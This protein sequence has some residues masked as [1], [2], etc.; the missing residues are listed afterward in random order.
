MRGIVKVVVF[1]F[2]LVTC[3]GA[4]ALAAQGG[5]FGRFFKK[6]AAEPR[7]EKPVSPVPQRTVSR[8]KVPPKTVAPAVTPSVPLG[9]GTTPEPSEETSVLPRELQ[10]MSDEG[11]EVNYITDEEEFKAY[12]EKLKGAPPPVR[13]PVIPRI[14]NYQQT[15][16]PRIQ[17]PPV[18]PNTGGAV[19]P[20]PLVRPT[21]APTP[22]PSVPQT[23]ALP[24]RAPQTPVRLPRTER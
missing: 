5:F 7:E 15:P 24:P 1:I 9:S 17:Q 20:S 19:V 12:E 18:I 16:V 23:P 11:I 3:A 13:A 8:P 14:P 2:F 10:E 4:D 21:M 22:V 6:Q